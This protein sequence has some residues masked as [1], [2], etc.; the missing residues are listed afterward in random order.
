MGAFSYVSGGF[1]YHTHIGR[2]CSLA[3]ELHIGQGNHPV[4][5][6]STHPFQYQSGIFDVRDS[7][8]FKAQY[9]ADQHSHIKDAVLDRP[10][11][12]KIG[13]DCWIGTGVY[14]RNGVTIG[15]GAVIGARSVVTK[16]IP[17]YA[18]AV[19]S[20]A[21]V[22]RFRFDDLLINRLLHL[23]WWNYAP[24]Q[25]RELDLSNPALALDKLEIMIEEGLECYKP[26]CLN[27]KR[28]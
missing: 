27:I 16:D 1:L 24:W 5:W 4:D 22:I 7:F 15:D 12:T 17:P 18:I 2:Y 21:R 23:Q 26:E 19:G 9:D 11:P 25:L 20:P 13:N 8:E 10:K 3:N 28:S 6:L 14:I